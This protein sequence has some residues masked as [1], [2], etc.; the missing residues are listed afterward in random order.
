MFL[1]HIFAVFYQKHVTNWTLGVDSAIWV[2]NGSL[3]TVI[4]RR[5]W[6][7]KHPKPV[8]RWQL[9]NP[10]VVFDRT[11]YIVG[12]FDGD[13]Y[14]ESRKARLLPGMD[15]VFEAHQINCLFTE[16]DGGMRALK[17]GDWLHEIQR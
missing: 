14:W 10:C 8:L 11:F 12:K 5:R 15:I 4:I 17:K 16:V 6:R 1:H 7:K 9:T 3:W 2:V 13:D